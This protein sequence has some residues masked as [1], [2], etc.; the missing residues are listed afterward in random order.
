MYYCDSNNEY[1]ECLKI[2]DTGY[3]FTNSGEVY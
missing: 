1:G 3:Y 2:E